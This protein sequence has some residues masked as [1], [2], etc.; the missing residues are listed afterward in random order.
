MTTRSGN[1][2]ARKIGGPYGGVVE[3]LA[4]TAQ[5]REEGTRVSRDAFATER[6][7]WT[8]PKKADAIS[9]CESCRVA[10]LSSAERSVPGA[11][12]PETVERRSEAERNAGQQST[13]RAQYRARLAQALA[14]DW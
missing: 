13:H 1:P 4:L 2:R 7:I 5:R 11:T 12:A 10:Q 3:L 9:W 14:C 6:R 8:I